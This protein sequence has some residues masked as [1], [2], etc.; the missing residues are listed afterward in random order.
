MQRYEQDELTELII[1]ACNTA[2][3]EGAAHMDTSFDVRGRLQASE[4]AQQA[5]REVWQALYRLAIEQPETAPQR[6][7]NVT[8]GQ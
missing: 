5:Q 2:R 4:I 6:I 1:R 7:I 3:E 8:S